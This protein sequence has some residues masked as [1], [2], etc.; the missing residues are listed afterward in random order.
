MR[1]TET[2][3]DALTQRPDLAPSERIV[4]RDGYLLGRN[5]IRSP[6]DNN[7]T[8]GS[9]ERA[10]ALRMLEQEIV[11]LDTEIQALDQRLQAQRARR[12]TQEAARAQAQT[13]IN[14]VGR[15][16]AALDS[17]LNGARQRLNHFRER[18]QR[19]DEERQELVDTGARF[20]AEIESHRL[21][22]HQALSEIDS[23]SERR[24]A[25]LAERDQLRETLGEAR[26]TQGRQRDELQR[27]TLSIRTARASRDLVQSALDRAEQQ[28]SGL[29]ERREALVEDMARDGD[30]LAEQRQA[31]EAQL[32]LRVQAES[33]LTDTRNQMEALDQ[34]V[35]AAEQRRQRL[36]QTI[37][38]LQQQSDQLRLARQEQVVLRRT[39]EEE[40]A[41]H[42]RSPQQVL[43]LLTEDQDTADVSTKAHELE[44]VRKRI[45][46][47]GNI[48]LAAI[49]EYQEQAERLHYLEQQHADIQAS[50][51]TLESAIRKIDRET[52]SRFKETFDQVNEGLQQLFP[53]VFGGGH[54]YLELTGEDMLDAAEEVADDM[55]DAA[56]GE[57]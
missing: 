56:E 45:Q 29:R 10:E 11:R 1:I 33:A 3:A 22:L 7:E 50:L 17:E 8:Q 24:D 48:N 47:L 21:N 5:W 44:Q 54:A 32:A 2:L 30:P 41:S 57:Y 13:Q 6:G 46:R 34:A 37:T 43:E 40:L 55:E 53:R 16:R 31:L 51:E 28:V 27:L 26:K 20:T 39:Q 36:E 19:L 18:Q 4:T 23:L 49:D 52:R 25:L 15:E 12:K 35:R 38:S 14:Q 9:L 42:E